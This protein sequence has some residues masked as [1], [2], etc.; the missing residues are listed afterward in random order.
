[1]KKV[2]VILF[3]FLIGIVNG[4]ETKYA[5][6]FLE[7]GV[8]ARA[9]G[10]GS[11]YAGLS[12]DAYGFYWNPAGLAFITNFQAASMYA[13]LFNALEKQSYVSAAMPI[14]GGSAV[15]VAWIRLSVD[16]IP[17]YFFDKGEK[18]LDPTLQLKDGPVGYF[19]NF[20]DAFFISFAKYT[21]WNIDLGWQ[22]FE[23]PIDIGG[24]LNFK[25]IRQALD[26]KTGSGLGVDAG[27]MMRL[28]LNDVFVED[29]Y[30]DFIFGINVQDITNT[31]ITWDTDSKH[32]DQIDRNFKYGVSYSQPLSFINSQLT[33]AYDI[34]SKYDGSTHLGGE[35]L[36]NSMLAVRIGANS[37]FFTTGAGVYFWKFK[38]D[39]AYQG[40]DLGNSH[41]VSVLFSF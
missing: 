22:Y 3:L 26:D 10:M 18:E 27:M 9:L 29:L 6:S 15:S 30:G 12:N 5:A 16:D 20:N 19:G 23:L 13:D 7:L 40:H 8:G 11:A 17:R 41:R 24:G 4:K 36:Y 28:N 32:K 35:F 33:V 37:G 31:K 38:F 25:I 1:M 21:K 2:S 34:N 39:Y 14:F